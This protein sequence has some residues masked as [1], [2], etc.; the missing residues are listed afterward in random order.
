METV[1]RKYLTSAIALLWVGGQIFVA[2][3]PVSGML[4]RPLHV[5]LALIIVFLS[6][7][8]ILRKPDVSLAIDLF[9]SAAVFFYMIHLLVSADRIETR[10]PFVDELTGS[11]I[12][13]S[14][15]LIVLLLEAGRRVLGRSMTIVALVF[16]CYS[17]FRANLPRR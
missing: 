5:G 15:I 16:V 11:D 14:I 7:P 2:F 6:K 17:F 4:I 3:S 12:F 1:V 9:F 13:L 10:I 8:A